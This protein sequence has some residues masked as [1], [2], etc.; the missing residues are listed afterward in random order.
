M[1]VAKGEY[2]DTSH[3]RQ[4]SDGWPHWMLVA[5]NRIDR[6][7]RS[8]LHDLTTDDSQNEPPDIRTNDDFEV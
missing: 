3:A 4:S 1:T 2:H 7:H 8:R 6:E 5:F